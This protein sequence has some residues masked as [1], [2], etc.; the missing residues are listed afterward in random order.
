MFYTSMNR[1]IQVFVLGFVFNMCI[2]IIYIFFFWKT[3][4]LEIFVILRLKFFYNQI[5]TSSLC[6]LI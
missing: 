1:S 5:N 6:L 2:E 4:L 3:H